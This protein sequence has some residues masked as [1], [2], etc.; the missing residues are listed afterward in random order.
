MTSTRFRFQGLGPKQ[1]A[2]ED[3]DQQNRC[4]SYPVPSLKLKALHTKPQDPLFT[5]Q[6][7]TALG[8]QDEEALSPSLKSS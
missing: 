4:V 5:K 6:N 1:Y 7:L 2:P 8:V 3:P